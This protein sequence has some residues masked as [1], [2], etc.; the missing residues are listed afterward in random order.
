MVSIVRRLFIMVA[1]F[2]AA[3]CYAATDWLTPEQIVAKIKLPQIP[4]QQFNIVDF[5][6]Q[7]GSDA[8]PAIMAAIAAASK[9]G[10]GK[11][12]IPKGKWL[13]NGPV[14][15][16]SRINLH[17]AEGA[18]L[19]FSANPAH[20][21][22]VVKVRW[23]GT[24]VFTY[25][26]LIY[27]ADVEDVAITGTGIVDGNA[28]SQFKSWHEHQWP[29]I[30]KLRK[31][32][33]TGVPAEQRVFGD[34]TYLRPDLIQFFNAE[35]V[36]LE[37]YTSTNSPFWVNHLVNTRHATLRQLKVD[38]HFHNND[39]VDIESSQLV[40]VEDCLFRTGDDSV[41]VK[42]GRDL[43]GRTIGIP[44]TDIVVRNNDMGGEDGIG[45]GSEMSGGI[46][47][48]YFLDNVLRQGD[49]AFRFKS[50]L[51]RGGLVEHV[52]IRNTKVESFTNLFWFQMNYPSELGGNFPSTYK[53][54]LFE[55]MTVANVTNFLEIHAPEAAPLQD[56]T[57]RNISVTKTE[58]NFN[59]ENAVGLK[60]DNVQLGEQ[61]FDGTM[62]WRRV[63]P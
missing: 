29:D 53:D 15:L 24:E 37:G 26:P 35:R 33:F 10:G 36:L 25:S 59:I 39:G 60:F 44:S 58:N 42:S 9:E 13:S 41:V 61:V 51:D 17:L 38:S 2:G 54:I 23:E 5:G 43:D 3:Q 57:F 7:S 55:D 45:L 50:N 47:N 20:Y 1:L 56:V 52:V 28:N 34:G 40:L 63:K 31:M 19:L 21:L 11:V 48:V 62:N 22:P 46:A 30:R 14:H 49:S 4:E 27:A 16:Q 18:H 8:R 32:G 12:I 6:A